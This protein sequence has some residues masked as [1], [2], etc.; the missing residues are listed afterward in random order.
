M[1]D[2]LPTP[3]HS[4][5]PPPSYS[6]DSV[7]SSDLV[8]HLDTLLAHY[9]V[10]LD[11]YTRLRA[12]LSSEFSSGFLS[13]AHANRNA[14]STLGAGRRYGPTE[15]DSRMKASIGIRSSKG[16]YTGEQAIVVSDSAKDLGAVKKT[17]EASTEA[18]EQQQQQQ[19]ETQ[20]DHHEINPLPQPLPHTSYSA[21]TISQTPQLTQPINW[22]G[23]FPPSALRQTQNTFTTS[24]TSTILELLTTISQMRSLEAEIWKV[25][26]ELGLE[27]YDV[28]GECRAGI[29]H[30]EKSAEAKIEAAGMVKANAKEASLANK[31]NDEGSVR[32][33][34]RTPVSPSKTQKLV[35]R[36]KMSEPRSRIIK[37]D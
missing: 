10:L 36:S 19:P 4:P 24:V 14:S 18:Q 30:E 5:P 22:F 32:T 28:P 7:S 25:R 2:P 20:T 9:L 17:V 6:T 11:T 29:D 26:D 12:R 23:L 16:I 8:S 27:G 33:K 34:E 31:D 37:L 15:F 1:S 21:T 35:S 3:P 13:L